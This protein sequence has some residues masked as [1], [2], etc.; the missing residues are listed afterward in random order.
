MCHP[1]SC[2]YRTKDH[3]QLS[4][5]PRQGQSKGS[6]D[7]CGPQDDLAMP[8][9]HYASRPTE[10]PG[11]SRQGAR[12]LWNMTS[13]H[14]SVDALLYTWL[15]VGSAFKTPQEDLA[16]LHVAFK[17]NQQCWTIL[18]VLQ[19]DTGMHMNTEIIS[20][21]KSALLPYS[22]SEHAES[23]RNYGHTFQID[24]VWCTKKKTALHGTARRQ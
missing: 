4:E 5:V 18:I 24:D 14:N 15:W 11:N 21:K 19:I 12:W 13:F 10:R 17:E 8:R 6:R 22:S 9:N 2:S 23:L 1:V 16:I 3:P 7:G 20:L